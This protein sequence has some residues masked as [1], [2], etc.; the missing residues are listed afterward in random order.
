MRITAL[1]I[2]RIVE[3]FRQSLLG[4]RI[5]KLRK[6]EKDKTVIMH[7]E[8]GDERFSQV[9]HFGGKVSYIYL[10][11]GFYTRITTT[12][13]LPQLM[14]ARINDISQ[15][16][17]DRI[18]QFDIEAEKESYR[19]VFELFGI[20]SNLYLSD[21]SNNVITSIRK[22]KLDLK[23]YEPPE[24]LELA[25]PLDFHTEDVMKRLMA[26]PELALKDAIP[27]TF[28]GLDERLL[29]EIA[30]DKYDI[31]S[32]AVSELI[33]ESI[34]E[35]LGNI[36]EY[37]TDFTDPGIALSYDSDAG[38]ILSAN[39]DDLPKFDSISEIFRQASRGQKIK[40]PKS[41]VKS[42][43]AG[44]LK[45]AIK[46]D[47]KKISKLDEQFEKA[48]DYPLIRQ[49]AELLGMNLHRAEKGMESI[50][51]DDVYSEDGA[52][53]KIEL[54]KTLSPGQNVERMFERAKKLKDKI[55]GIKAEI[56]LTGDRLER[57]GNLKAELESIETEDIP[58]R[59][60]TELAEFGIK[61][62]GEG[63]K[64]KSEERLPYKKYTS[65]LGEEILV[66]RSASDN[67]V[68][69]FKFAR[70]YDLWLHS[71]QTAGSHVILR[72][73]NKNHQFQKSSIVEA[74][75]IAA[76]FSTAKKSDTVPVI[77]TEVKYVRKV[78]KGKPGQVIADRTKS[79]LVTPRRPKN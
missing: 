1:H 6:S 3:E 25:N 68:L 19:L 12:N 58:D 13:F 28:S 69:T 48:Q 39:K 9:F 15:L 22:A 33:P 79:I 54:D 59:L 42:N 52:M 55:P 36:K 78:R 49:K 43:L 61:A 18:I 5:R 44:Q 11:F 45:R 40:K 76:F 21:N 53:V 62:P 10:V 72:R 46:K 65:S 7:L 67:D 30:A 14:D 75:E 31:L 77:Y 41:S 2:A 71:Q 70:K 66:G 23:K 8:S 38:S 24:P 35:L 50:E 26:S 34:E 32:N 73:P 27:R 17:F 47:T 29:E 64:A 56:Y 57:L 51:V 16:D 63:K 37:C 74:A 20:S 60:K 4:A